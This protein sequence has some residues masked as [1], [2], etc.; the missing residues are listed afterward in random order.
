[1]TPKIISSLE[2]FSENIQINSKWR[3]TEFLIQSMSSNTILLIDR[4]SENLFSLVTDSE[5][6]FYNC[7]WLRMTHQ[8]EYM[9]PKVICF[10]S[11]TPKIITFLENDSENNFLYSQ[12]LRKSFYLWAVI[13][14]LIFSKYYDFERLLINFKWL[15]IFFYVSRWMGV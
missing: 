12:W 8:S 5:R 10:I 4:N 3:R 7:I 11:R 6:I 15:R 1:M 2:N 13:P 9:I 14:K